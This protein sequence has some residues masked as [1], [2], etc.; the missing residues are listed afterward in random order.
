MRMLPKCLLAVAVTTAA[1]ALLFDRDADASAPAKP[2]APPAA[3]V[4]VAPAVATSFA[5]RHWAPGSVISRDDARV[6]SEQGG[7]IVRIAEV[8]TR[9]RSGDA[10]AVLDDTALRLREREAAA[11]LG[12]IRSQLDLAIRQEAR[13]AQLAAQQ[14]I[15]RAQHDQLQ[16]DRDMLAQ[17][18]ASAEALLAQIRHQRSQMVIRAPF[19]GLVVERLAQL[20][21]YLAAG[22]AVARL[23]DTDD[24]EVRVRAPVDLAKNL[25]VG[26]NVLVRVAGTESVNT[27]SALVPVGDEASRQ[28]ELRIAMASLQLPVGTALE[29]GLPS[30]S[31]RN[32]LAVPRDA[33]ILRREGSFVLR[34]DAAD[35]AERIAVETGASLDGL[36]EVQGDLR[37]G[38]RLIVRGGERVQPGQTVAIQELAQATAMR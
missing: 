36:V 32:V 29:V 5:P 9:L 31:E 30:A 19:P 23:V 22:E 13:Y 34:V 10:L 1:A 20:G 2:P 15:A 17:E 37:A 38:D 35:K 6:A 33:V 28:L 14:N 12:R 7:R 26:G 3:I 24:L 18:R 25:R 16:A 27:I 21:E 8:G 4:D 11:N